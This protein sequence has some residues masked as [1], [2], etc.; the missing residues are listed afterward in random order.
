MSQK[1]YIFVKIALIL[2]RIKFPNNTSI[3][4]AEEEKLFVKW[5]YG[6]SRLHTHTLEILVINRL[7]FQNLFFSTLIPTWISHRM[8][9]V[10]NEH[11]HPYLWDDFKEEIV[12][13]LIYHHLLSLKTWWAKFFGEL[14]THDQTIIYETTNLHEAELIWELDDAYVMT[15]SN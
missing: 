9:I 3:P 6:W 13:R 5:G 11:L 2:L 14:K 15:K 10:N 7:Y 8:I 12:R 1:Q 4:H